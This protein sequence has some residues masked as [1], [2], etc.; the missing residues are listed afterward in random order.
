MAPCADFL[1]EQ[2]FVA[3]LYKYTVQNNLF[4]KRLT[5]EKAQTLKEDR[6]AMKFSS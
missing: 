1:S 2:V 4:E 3:M 6:Q 5:Q